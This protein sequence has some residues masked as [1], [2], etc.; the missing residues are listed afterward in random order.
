MIKKVPRSHMVKYLLGGGQFETSEERHG[1]EII[2]TK[3]V[4]SFF[5]RKFTFD[6]NKATMIA[7]FFVEGPPQSASDT[8]IEEKE[9]VTNRESLIN[10]LREHISDY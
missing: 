3:S 7:R 4:V 8:Q 5:E 10:R 2:R 1:E 9:H 6:R